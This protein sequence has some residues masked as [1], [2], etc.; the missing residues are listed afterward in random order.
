MLSYFELYD[1]HYIICCIRSFPDAALNLQVIE[2]VIMVLNNRNY[3]NNFNQLRTALQ[4]LNK[5]DIEGRYSFAQ[6]K[7][8]YCYYP[9]SFLKNENI[10]LVL[11]KS[12]EKLKEAI[13][14]NNVEKIYDLADCIHNLP[15]YLSENKYMIPKSFWKKEVRC[16]REKW[17]KTFLVTEQKKMK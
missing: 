4:P 1:L 5:F 12:C 13:I 7:N 15:I 11:C 17:D 9:L 16:Y 2:A 3:C 10:Y 14:E 8:V 6:I